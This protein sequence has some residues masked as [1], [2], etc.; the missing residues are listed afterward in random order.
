MPPTPAAKRSAATI[1]DSLTGESDAL[2]ARCFAQAR[3][4]S[5]PPA[6]SRFTASGARK[7][8]EIWLRKE[9]R[10]ARIAWAPDAGMLLVP[11]EVPGMMVLPRAMA[12]GLRQ[13]LEAAERGEQGRL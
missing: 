12:A 2:W 6:G 4:V 7:L 10:T 1:E 9:V 13:A 3:A 11:P 8:H 5:A